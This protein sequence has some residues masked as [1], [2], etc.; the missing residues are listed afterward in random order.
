MLTLKQLLNNTR[1]HRPSILDK[2][3]KVSVTFVRVDKKTDDGTYY[4]VLAACKGDTSPKRVE[5][6]I[7]GA[8]E[9]A[10]VWVRCSCEY[11]KFHVEYALDRKDST[12]LKYA[13]NRAPKITNPQ[14]NCHACK[15]VVAC[16]YRGAA[17]SGFLSK[18]LSKLKKK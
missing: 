2:A 1:T 11:F 16:F 18:F 13:I 5:L 7:W 8:G 9:S 6:K 4:H 17:D 10:K 15:H 12:D 3:K 14:Q